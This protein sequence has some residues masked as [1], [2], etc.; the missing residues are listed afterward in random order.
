MMDKNWM[1][2]A[3][4][5]QGDENFKPH[6]G[7]FRGFDDYDDLKASERCKF[8]VCVE[9]VGKEMDDAREMGVVPPLNLFNQ[10]QWKGERGQGG[11][12]GWEYWT[13]RHD[14]IREHA[15]KV[16]EALGL[17][18]DVTEIDAWIATGRTRWQRK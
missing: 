18:V 1:L 4:D 16:A 9:R 3:E 5:L 12:S 11:T 6:G 14:R 10:S 13:D 7:Y 17:A 8:D 15:L 2:F